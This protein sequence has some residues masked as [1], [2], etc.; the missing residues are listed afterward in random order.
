MRFLLR[1]GR[2]AQSIL[3]ARGREC[4]VGDANLPIGDVQRDVHR[5]MG[6][7]GDGKFEAAR[8]HPDRLSRG[9]ANAASGQGPQNSEKVHKKR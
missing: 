4:K 2:S 3:G 6:V 7:A 9:R 8:G 1:S 5:E